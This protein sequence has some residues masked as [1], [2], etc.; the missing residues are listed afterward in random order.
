MVDKFGLIESMEIFFNLMISLSFFV[1]IMLVVS[2]EAFDHF[3]CALQKE[4]G[5]RKKIIPSVEDSANHFV[6]WLILKYPFFA[7][8]FISVASFALM[9]VYK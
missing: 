3:N 1:G 9:M 2:T 4:F 7:G 8:I 6:D 5:I